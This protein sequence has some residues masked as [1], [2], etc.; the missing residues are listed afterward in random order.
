VPGAGKYVAPIAFFILAGIPAV[1]LLWDALNHLF[2]GQ[3][4]LTRMLMGFGG[5]V[6]LVLLLAML[7]R[8]L[9]RWEAR[10]SEEH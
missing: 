5:L 10:R 6:L 2:A 9:S 1:A 4:H 8:T 7:A 3:I